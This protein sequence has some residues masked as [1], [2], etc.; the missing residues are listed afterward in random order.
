MT[1]SL[2]F[3]GVT[4][5]RPERDLTPLRADI[6]NEVAGAWQIVLKNVNEALVASAQ[7]AVASARARRCRHFGDGH[8]RFFN[9]IITSMHM[10]SIIESAGRP[11]RSPRP[12]QCT[13]STLTKRSRSAKW[14]SSR[15]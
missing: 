14:P 8:Q 15:R 9:R 5:E 4:Y 1:R 7:N 10:P 6:Y 3:D 12:R 11:V 13:W 2:S